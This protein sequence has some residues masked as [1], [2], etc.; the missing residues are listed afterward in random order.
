[1]KKLL[2]I[3]MAGVLVFSLASCSPSTNENNEE[4]QATTQAQSQEETQAETQATTTAGAYTKAELKEFYDT[5]DH[6]SK[7]Y[8]ELVAHYGGVEPDEKE[9]GETITNYKYLAK[10]DAQAYVQYMEEE[11]EG[12]VIIVGKKSY[13]LSDTSW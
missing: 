6:S 8:D 9:E 3:I 1:M 13:M 7:T 5:F 10:D 4:T 11:R 12:E 2:V